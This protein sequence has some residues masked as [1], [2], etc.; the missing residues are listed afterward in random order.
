M[1]GNEV[2]DLATAKVV[3]PRKADKAYGLLINYEY[4]TGCYSCQMSCSVS[5]DIPIG[6]FGIKVEQVGPWH[7]EGKAWQNDYMPL[8][9]D[10]C[11]LCAERTGKGKLPLCVKHCQAACME[12][13]TVEELAAKAAAAT[14]KHVLWIPKAGEVE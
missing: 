10:E 6:H 5:H 4:C 7:I 3:E 9:T 13:G 12:Y 14:T 1:A 11:D 2:V 8:P